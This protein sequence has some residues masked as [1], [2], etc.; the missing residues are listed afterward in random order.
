MSFLATRIV[1]KLDVVSKNID[2]WAHAVCVINT[3]VYCTLS[4]LH[5]MQ[6]TMLCRNRKS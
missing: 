5:I 1:L 4:I 2:L 3:A 6:H